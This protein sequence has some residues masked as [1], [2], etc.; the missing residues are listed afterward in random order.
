MF[1]PGWTNLYV[2]PAQRANVCIS[3]QPFSRT[4]SQ[5]LTRSKV[6]TCDWIPNLYPRS[7]SSLSGLRKRKSCGHIRHVIC[8]RVT[9]RGLQDTR[10]APLKRSVPRTGSNHLSFPNQG[11]TPTSKLWEIIQPLFYVPGEL[12]LNGNKSKNWTKRLMNCRISSQRVCMTVV[13]MWMNWTSSLFYCTKPRYEIVRRLSLQ[14]T[15]PTR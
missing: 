9:I 10:I 14:M 13:S 1:C 15:G 5:K 4:L 8:F 7:E 2:N 12:L 11:F 6:Y 3:L